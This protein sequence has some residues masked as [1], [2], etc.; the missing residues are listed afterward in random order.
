MMVKVKCLF[1]EQ[2]IS[3]SSRIHIADLVSCSNCK[4]MFRV[5]WL[6]PL[7]IDWLDMNENQDDPKTRSSAEVQGESSIELRVEEE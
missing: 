1:C 4:T 2:Q 6:Y 3:V 5:V 7:E